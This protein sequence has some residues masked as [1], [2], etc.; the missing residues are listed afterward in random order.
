MS[1]TIL[2]IDLGNTRLKW[3]QRDVERT[4]SEGAL[5]YR[6][7]GDLSPLA[8]L[9]EV[10]RVRIA[11]VVKGPAFEQL[12]S[13]LR[14]THS[15]DPEL[16]QVQKLCAGVR[17]AYRDP[18]RL[19]VDRWLCLLA[20][21][22]GQQPA[23]VMSSGSAI[24]VDLLRAD[25]E[26]LGGYIVPGFDMMRRALFEGTSAV[27]L[28]T[29]KPPSSLAPGRDTVEAVN[30]GLLVMA[31]GLIEHAVIQMRASDGEP[32]VLITGGAAEQLRAFLDGESVY[33]PHL[34]LDGLAL[35]LP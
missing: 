31:R 12:I 26:H 11:S 22:Q 16:A 21:H 1:K 15:C 10:A 17:Q 28:D 23:V 27:K 9:S 4:L 29:L 14:L 6:E 2:D 7:V 18:M 34:V 5:V 13:Y 3:R 32:R 25:G 35:A 30:A 24:T 8:E 33:N 19:G 20:A